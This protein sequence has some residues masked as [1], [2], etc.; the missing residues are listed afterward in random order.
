MEGRNFEIKIPKEKENNDTKIWNNER[1]F[2]H[3][4][5]ALASRNV[6][7]VITSYFS[8]VNVWMVFN[9]YTLLVFSL[10]QI[11]IN[12]ICNVI[13]DFYRFNRISVNALRSRD[14]FEL[15]NCFICRLPKKKIDD[16]FV[17]IVIFS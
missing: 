6:R 5:K 1:S 10:D 17:N 14:Q 8:D 9:K 3:R 12:L 16:M 4:K 15:C 11:E 13:C 7:C 2:N